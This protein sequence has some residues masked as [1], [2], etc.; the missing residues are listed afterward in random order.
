[1]APDAEQVTATVS[2]WAAL[3]Q[4]RTQLPPGRGQAGDAPPRTPQPPHVPHPP[5]VPSKPTVIS[6]W[7]PGGLPAK[8]RQQGG[9]GEERPGSQLPGNVPGQSPPT[10]CPQESCVPRGGG[11]P[12]PDC[13]CPEVVLGWS[14]PPRPNSPSAPALL[15]L[16]PCGGG[17]PCGWWPFPSPI[18]PPLSFCSLFFC[19]EKPDF[20]TKKDETTETQI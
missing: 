3:E 5:G 19:P 9:W 16:G 4:R 20:D 12:L 10:K 1:M 2:Q 17:G 8:H 11:A 14:C 13:R 6:P 7:L 15:P 18:F